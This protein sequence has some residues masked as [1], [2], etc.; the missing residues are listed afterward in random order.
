MLLV[1]LLN[2]CIFCGVFAVENPVPAS[3]LQPRNF[4]PHPYNRHGKAFLI[5]PA[6]NYQ[7]FPVERDFSAL[8]R[9]FQEF[10][11]SDLDQNLI[12]NF[13]NISALDR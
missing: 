8:S 1:L 4:N 13:K 11:N 9:R 3:L 12:Q 2:F 6:E 10:V 5:A 7:N